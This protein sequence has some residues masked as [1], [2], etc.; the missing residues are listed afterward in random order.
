MTTPATGNGKSKLIIHSPKATLHV[1]GRQVYPGRDEVALRCE[2]GSM[3]FRI[4][5]KPDPAHDRKWA[6]GSAIVCSNQGCLKVIGLTPEGYL[7]IEGVQTT[8]P[9]EE[10]DL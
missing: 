5:V 6:R 7:D 3:K 9:V 10:Q 4:F 2:C 1:P 8:L